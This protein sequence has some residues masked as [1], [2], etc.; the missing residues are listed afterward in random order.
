[1][2]KFWNAA[3]MLAPQ[4]TMR[5]L[6]ALDSIKVRQAYDGA[7]VGRR[8]A[9]FRGRGESANSAVGPALSK[10]RD[11]SSD[12]VRNSWL[13]ARILD[14]LVA[15]VIG[16]GITVAWENDK[17]QALWNEWTAQ[18]DIEGVQ[19]FGGLQATA[20]RSMFERGDSVVRMVPRR[21]NSGRR[22]P[23]ALQ[24]L[25]GDFIDDMR[26]GPV[27]N[28]RAR[29]G[30]VLGEWGEREGLYLFGE[31]P[32]EMGLLGASRMSTFIPRGDVCH[33]YRT[34]RPGQVR[35][36]PLLAP[37]L[38]AA[39]DFADVMDAIVIKTR[40]EACYGLIITSQD[41]KQNLSSAVTGTTADGATTEEVRPGMIYRGRPGDTVTPFNPAGA[42]QFEPVAFAALCAIASGG[43]VT[44][45]QLTGD[46]R[47]A[48]Y[49][50]LRAGKIEFRRLVEQLQW[51]VAV[52][53]L[54]HRIVDRFKATAMLAGEL[55]DRAA[56][57]ACEF[58]MPAVEP[59]DP[60]KDLKADILAV[61]SGR[62][63]PQEFIGAWGRDWRAVL[64]EH[65]E[66]W[67][68]ADEAGAVFDIDPRRVNQT[69]SAQLADEPID[70]PNSS[71]EA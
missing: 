35:G 43:M 62:L 41:P 23:L 70:P 2:S 60:L 1:M 6:A 34:L 66:F 37:V 4:A 56:G 18:A 69:G 40:M 44:Y 50:S 58:V 24:V 16:T 38:M 32:G 21:M 45:D 47:R 11:R 10:L 28:R 8:G 30:V 67:K 15:H 48:N 9:S 22:V 26:D 31:H 5:R 59:I 29:L 71:N 19:D 12:M 68:E 64:A 33:L 61:R 46:L 42:G 20:L 52:P 53:G 55:R 51:L 25:E 39:R 17:L 3:A 27:E 13:G 14:V 63:S 49:S 36:V 54:M 7:V 65:K 57:Y